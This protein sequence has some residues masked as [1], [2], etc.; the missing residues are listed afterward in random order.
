MRL[1]AWFLSRA[2]HDGDLTVIDADGHAHRFG[3]PGAR[4]RSVVRLV[5]HGVADALLLNPEVA[6]AEA[7]MDGT[8]VPEDGTGVHDL[9][10][11][12]AANRSRF[13]RRAPG[14]LSCPSQAPGPPM[15]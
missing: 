2:I 11:V 4:P 6:V 9:L 14:G 7:Y 8:L 15:R 12:H 10:A 3:R 13:Q 1:L 5:R